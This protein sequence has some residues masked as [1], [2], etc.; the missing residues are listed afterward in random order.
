[1]SGAAPLPAEELG[2]AVGRGGQAVQYPGLCAVGK[3]GVDYRRAT[4]A[5]T[6]HSAAAW[7]GDGDVDLGAIV[8]GGGD[9]GSRAGRHDNLT[10]V[11]GGKSC[12]AAPGPLV[13]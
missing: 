12:R 13:K 10:C 5:A 7:A 4:A 6:V 11:G 9:V 2:T 1:M 8:E 3:L